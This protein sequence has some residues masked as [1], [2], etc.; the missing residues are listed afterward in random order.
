MQVTQTPFYV[1]FLLPG[2]RGMSKSKQR[3]V[4]FK[5]QIFKKLLVRQFNRGNSKTLPLLTWVKQYQTYSFPIS[6]S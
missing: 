4:Q 5:V 2:S 3:E 1:N 6:K